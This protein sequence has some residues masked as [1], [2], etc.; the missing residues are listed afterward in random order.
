MNNND[1][2][3]EGIDKLKNSGILDTFQ[4]NF[5]FFIK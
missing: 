1:C 4:C 3:N 5:L 2:S